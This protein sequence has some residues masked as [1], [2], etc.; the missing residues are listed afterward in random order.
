MHSTVNCLRAVCL[1]VCHQFSWYVGCYTIE[2][3]IL[4]PNLKGQWAGAKSF[5]AFHQYFIWQGIEGQGMKGTQ[6]HIHSRCL[7]KKK[8]TS[9]VHAHTH[10][11]LKCTRVRSGN[12]N[13]TIK[14]TTDSF[15]WAPIHTRRGRNASH[16]TLTPTQGIIKP[17]VLKGRGSGR[18]K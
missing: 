3:T 16:E 10:T 11:H 8:H 1:K 5:S 18:H 14:M 6:T 4:K 9:R 7:W 13:T 2:K 15:K 17:L 12:I